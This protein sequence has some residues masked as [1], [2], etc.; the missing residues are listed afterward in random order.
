MHSYTLKFNITHLHAISV[1]DVAT[2]A[3]LYIYIAHIM[4]IWGVRLCFCV[5]VC[6]VSECVCVCLC[7]RAFYTYVCV[8]MCACV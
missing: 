4:W 7:V 8:C 2:H 1:K 6:T 5:H 3:S